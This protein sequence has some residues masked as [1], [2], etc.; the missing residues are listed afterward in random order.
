MTQ[1]GGDDQG[2]LGNAWDWLTQPAPDWAQ[3][4]DNLPGMGSM[5]T[6]AGQGLL[7]DD[8]NAQHA[9]DAARD[10]AQDAL[11]VADEPTKGVLGP[12]I[13]ALKDGMAPLKDV[14]AVADGLMKLFLPSN[15][16]R[17]VAAICG[18]FLLFFGISL[19]VR[20]VRS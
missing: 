7:P 18:I 16:V 12:A 14:Q 13:D 17:A 11:D 15:I 5:N 19:L 20:E 1:P 4:P 3:P 9:V 6:P 2:F 8:S 10:A